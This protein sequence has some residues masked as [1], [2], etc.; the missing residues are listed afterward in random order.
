MYICFAEFTVSAPP[1]NNFTRVSS[2]SLYF[3]H[4]WSGSMGVAVL[5]VCILPLY[6]SGDK[7]VVVGLWRMSA[8]QS[9]RTVTKASETTKSTEQNKTRCNSLHADITVAI[10]LKFQL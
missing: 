10:Q 2:S 5:N 1:C 9:M 4:N 8:A 6:H 3:R 7:T